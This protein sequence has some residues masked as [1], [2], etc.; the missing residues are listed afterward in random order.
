MTPEKILEIFNKTGALL[1]GHFQLTSGLHS[2]HYLQCALVLQ[3]PQY[4][5][6]LGAEIARRFKDEEIEVVIAPAVGG[7][8]VAQEVARLLKARAIF[9]ERE[10]G[11]MRLRRGFKIKKGEKVL[12]VEDVLTTGGSL[13]ETMEVAKENGGEIK[14]VGM[15]VDRSG[16]K[17]ELGA[18]KEALLVL[19]LENYEPEKCPL[20]EQGIPLEK[21]GSKEFKK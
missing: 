5:F 13:K 7:I 1:K 19:D 8:V 10:G 2:S 6:R 12:V 20:C 3:Y 15:L 4:A 17:V 9:S 14:G 18:P 21:P 16:G 11:G